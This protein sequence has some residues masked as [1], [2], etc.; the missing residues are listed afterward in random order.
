MDTATHLPG[1]GP[2]AGPAV[3]VLVDPPRYPAHGRW[4]AHLASDSSLEELH[5]FAAALDV[6]RGAFEGD[7]YDVPAEL[8][9]RAVARGAE[10]VATR[11]L[12]RRVR[13]AGLRT[14]KRRGEKVLGTAVVAGARV[15][16]VRAARVPAP[17]GTHGLLVVT[18]DAVLLAP[19]GRLP[20]AA[21]P[22][23]R[24]VLGFRR[25]WRRAGGRTAVVHDGLLLPADG[26]RPAT[27]V[28]AVPLD[29]PAVATAWWWPL[30]RAHPRA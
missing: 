3:S 22:G 18:G 26:D 17:H 30:V 6:P 13:A 4:W 24:P 23:Q 8:V 5:A 20:P 11:E 27:G 2:G 19:D 1:R 21:E 12:L 14:P 25:T 10:P 9:E 28:R 29:D 15:D 7:H 16:V